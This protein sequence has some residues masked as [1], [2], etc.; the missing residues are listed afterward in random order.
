M[1]GKPK[2]KLSKEERK[3]RKKAR[4]EAARLR[5][6]QKEIQ[7][8]KDRLDRETK[9][10]EVNAATIKSKW[11]SILRRLRAPQLQ[12]DFLALRLRSERLMDMKRA[13]IDELREALDF[14]NDQTPP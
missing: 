7:A 11:R 14:A 6:I 1:V 9:A 2:A 13:M 4:R 3:A 8:K 12:D 5:R 10:T